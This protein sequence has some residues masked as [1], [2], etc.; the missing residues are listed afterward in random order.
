MQKKDDFKDMLDL[1]ADR[2]SEPAKRSSSNLIPLL[3]I[4]IGM[5]I[6]SDVESHTF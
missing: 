1:N 4:L 6:A 2:L 3:V 5:S